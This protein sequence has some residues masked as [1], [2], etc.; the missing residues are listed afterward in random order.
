LL[1][2]QSHT[3]EDCWSIAVLTYTN[4]EMG[5]YKHGLYCGIA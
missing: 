3:Y 2:C 5:G 1:T 4:M